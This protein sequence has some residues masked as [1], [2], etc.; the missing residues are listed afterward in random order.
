RHQARLLLH[1]LGH[2]GQAPGVFPG[3]QLG[4]L[5]LAGGHLQRADL[6]DALLAELLEHV[7]DA[8]RAD[9]VHVPAVIEETLLAVALELERMTAEF[10]DIK[11]EKTD[12]HTLEQQG[13]CHVQ[14]QTNSRQSGPVGLV[15]AGR[16]RNYYRGVCKSYTNLVSTWPGPSPVRK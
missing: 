15:D 9:L 4:R 2:V 12:A 13:T 11:G 5:A 14:M 8:V 7:G 1:A 3:R 16:R 6:V 10:G